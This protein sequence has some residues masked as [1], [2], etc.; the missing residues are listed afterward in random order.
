MS[1]GRSD[2]EVISLVIKGDQQAYTE[3]V[4]KYRDY[5]FTLAL[6]FC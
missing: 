3:L 5:V 6:R 1:S 4:E 2:K